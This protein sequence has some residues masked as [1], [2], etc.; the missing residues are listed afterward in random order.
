[1]TVLRKCLRTNRSEIS[2]E[3][4]SNGGAKGAEGARGARGAR[5]GAEKGRKNERRT[6]LTRWGG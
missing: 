5:G 1:M 6:K 2:F 3:H 4:E